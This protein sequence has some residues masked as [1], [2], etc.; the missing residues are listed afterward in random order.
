[1]RQD[2]L[3]VALQLRDKL[4]LNDVDCSQNIKGAVFCRYGFFGNIDD[5]FSFVFIAMRLIDL[6][7]FD[8]RAS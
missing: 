2:F 4:V 3:F 6:A 5:D 1:M 7:E 8:V